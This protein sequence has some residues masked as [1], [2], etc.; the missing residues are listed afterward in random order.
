M[1]FQN[2]YSYMPVNYKADSFLNKE[3]KSAFVKYLSWLIY[4]Y[5]FIFVGYL[6][7][8]INTRGEEAAMK[9]FYDVRNTTYL[10]IT[11]VIIIFYSVYQFA[12]L[13]KQA[14][15]EERYQSFIPNLV[16]AVILVTFAYSAASF[17]YNLIKPFL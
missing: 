15:Q 17:F 3:K 10:V 1:V 6:I 7:R 2:N 5:F 4:S 8:V 11:S 13:K 9:V 14:I 16:I 12:K